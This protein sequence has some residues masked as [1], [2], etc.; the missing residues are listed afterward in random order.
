MLLKLIQIIAKFLE[1]LGRKDLSITREGQV[2]FERYYP[3][4]WTARGKTFTYPNIVLHHML[5]PDSKKNWHDHGRACISII[6]TGGYDELREGG[7]VLKRRPGSISFLTA[8][9]LHNVCNVLPNTWTI[10]AVGR[11]VKDLVLAGDLTSE[12]RVTRTVRDLIGETQISGLHPCTPE[13]E[14]R[15]AKRQA[16]AARLRRQRNLPSNSSL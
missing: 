3:L 7:V 14:A 8:S 1:K 11:R 13:L 4:P 15:I 2:M 10:F 12:K 16:A 9:T 5:K 6:L